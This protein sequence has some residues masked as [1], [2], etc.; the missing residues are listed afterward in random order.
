MV[1]KSSECRQFI[2]LAEQFDLL[3]AKPLF[4][5]SFKDALEYQNDF[6]TTIP[7]ILGLPEIEDNIAEG[8]VIKPEN[9]MFFHDGSRL[10]LKNKN[11]KIWREIFSQRTERKVL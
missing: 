2:D 10:I 8:V 6:Q 4:S 11:A 3:Y 1:I 7:G 9:A 5:G